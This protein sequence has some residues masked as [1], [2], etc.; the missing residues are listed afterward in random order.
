MYSEKGVKP[1]VSNFFLLYCKSWRNYCI[2]WIAKFY[3]RM[4]DI[5]TQ[6]ID[7]QQKRIYIYTY[8]GIFIG[9]TY[10]TLNTYIPFFCFQ[11]NNSFSIF[12]SRLFYFS[13]VFIIFIRKTIPYS[14]INPL[15]NKMCFTLHNNFLP[16]FKTN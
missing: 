10:N 8:I 2:L 6:K 1:L 15:C 13:R 16:L 3:V 12:F 7:R 9:E 14:K 4:G 11:P 5:W